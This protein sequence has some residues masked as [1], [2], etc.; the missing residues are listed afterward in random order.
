[1]NDPAWLGGEYDSQPAAGLALARII[2]MISYRSGVSFQERFGREVVPRNGSVRTGMYAD[3]PLTYQV[4][5]YLR[6][7]GQ[8][9]VDRFDA[10]SYIVLTNAMDAHDI[11]Y[12]R[13]PEPEVLGSIRTRTLSIGIS[14]DVLYPAADMKALA[15]GI[16]EARYAEI[17]S[18]H[19]HDAFL[20]EFD[21]LN[22][23]LA[24]FLH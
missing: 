1:M 16:P 13:G 20:L 15:K 21:Q 8:K 14:S 24:S 22:N 4:E 19:G 2:A 23:L 12:D 5:S 3:Y 10:N 6:H 9:L 17:S 11:C 18:I 7:Q